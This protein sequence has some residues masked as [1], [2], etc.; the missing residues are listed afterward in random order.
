MRK[1][2]GK[3]DNYPVSYNRSVSIVKQR[4]YVRYIERIVLVVGDYTAVVMALL[5]ACFLRERLFAWLFPTWPA[6]F[7]SP[8]Y[9]FGII[10]AVYLAFLAYDGLYT[11]RLP[12]WQGVERLFRICTYVSIL[13]IVLLYFL[14]KADQISRL[15]VG[16]GWLFSFITICCV[17]M[18]LKRIMVRCGI[19]QTPV[20]LIG[21]GRTAEL[22]YQ[23]FSRERNLGYNIVGVIEDHRAHRPLAQQL[24][25]WGTFQEAEEL[26]KR[27]GVQD[28]ILATPGMPRTKM[29]ELLYRLQPHVRNLTVVPDLFGVP[30]GNI[31]VDTLFNEKTVLL[32]VHNNLLRRKNRFFKRCFDI[33]ACLVGGIIFAPILGVIT[34]LVKLSS[35]GPAVFSHQRVGE[36]GILFP[37][38]KFRTMVTNGDEVLNQYFAHH[39]EAKF[40][41][42]RDFK[43][44]DD[45]RV[46]KMGVWLRKTSLDEL[47]QLL[48]V[49][50]GEMSLVGPRPIIQAEV[51]R[52]EEYIND[53][54]IV[55]P[56]ITGLW[57]VSGRSD[58]D[59]PERVRMD[60][61]YVRNWS[62][63]LDM[64]ILV[65]T[66]GVVTAKRGAY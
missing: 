39:P 18:G 53:Y 64:V 7:Y 50:R 59:Y 6:F 49:I 8:V 40:E 33:F 4:F 54:Y 27:S 5:I 34:L 31:T 14:G 16:M 11:R 60:S 58:I 47:P 32:R 29:L 26:V 63:W 1:E 56:G 23:G 35:P 57:Q 36:H 48:N 30:M 13:V 62:V 22:L 19:L 21:A 45:P 2:D 3:L 43:L 46:T 28:V 37:C 12:L 24:P 17:R 9:I 61:W 55:K 44:K 25:Y 42:E 51:P 41:W 38:Y 52:Y 66:V 15:V 20:V 10:P 65:K